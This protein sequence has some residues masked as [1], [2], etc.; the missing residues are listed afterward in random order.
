MGNVGDKMKLHSL[1]DLESL[2]PYKCKSTTL[3]DSKLEH[4]GKGKS[5]RIVLETKGRRGKTVTIV[6][7]LHHNPA[8]MEEIARI[9]K[10][11]CSAGGSVKNGCVEIQ[12][13]QQVRVNQ[14]LR[15]MNYVV[16]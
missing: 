15:T 9:L 1:S 12:G 11:H 14:K 16:K 8:T 5:V 4:D 3:P 6:S 2:L 13:D 7:G 10:Q